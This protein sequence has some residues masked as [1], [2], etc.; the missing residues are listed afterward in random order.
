MDW[1][2][3]TL[4]LAVL[5]ALLGVLLWWRAD[6]RARRSRTGEPPTPSGPPV[7]AEMDPAELAAR[8]TALDRQETAVAETLWAPEMEAQ[9][10]GLLID[11]LWQ[12]LNQT[13]DDISVL[14]TLEFEVIRLPTTG[15]EEAAPLGIRR[16]R[17]GGSQ[18]LEAAGWRRWLEARR[19]EGWRLAAIEFRHIAFDPSTNGLPAR[20]RFLLRLH[21]MR[22]GPPEQRA[23]VTGVMA[24]TW[25][26][27]PEPEAPP[28][29]KRVDLSAIQWALREGRPPFRP[30]LE[31]RLEPPPRSFFTDPLLVR[32]M[33]G[34]GRPKVI[35]ASANTLF[36]LRA[37][38]WVRE[39]WLPDGPG[40]IFTALIE[41]FDADGHLDLLTARFGGLYLFRGKP[42]GGFQ[43]EAEQVWTAEPRLRYA[44]ALT[45][46][47]VDH[48][49]DLD[50]WLGQYKGPYTGGQMPTPW[51]DAN[52][53]HPS[54]LLLNDGHGRFQDAT[55]ERGLAAKRFRR[56]Y[57]ASF[58]DLDLDG[59][60]DLLVVSDFAGVDLYLNDGRGFFRDVTTE[61]IDERHGFGMAHL[62]SD[63][64]RDGLPEVLVTGMHCP[65]AWRLNHL[66][67]TRAPDPDLEM[68]MRRLMTEGCRLYYGTPEGRWRQ[69]P[70]G[71][72]LAL[73][74]WS[75]GCAAPD[76]QNDGFPDV[77]I[78]NGHETRQ[79]ATDYEPYFWLHD[80]HVADSHEDPAKDA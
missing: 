66:G 30:W 72:D 40:L 4:R 61:R 31:A 27:P 44:Q 32:D 56:T 63:F 1:N 68:R 36:R 39:H 42:A 54:W 62:I 74:G 15:N 71:A 73:A 14:G 22:S 24:V 69:L 43:P 77:Y 19:Q 75:W 38:G 80:I 46:G 58:A 49:G 76:V 7:S 57:G 64:N 37:K 53:G 70:T 2:S 12:A 9:R 17:P 78:A 20:S 55:A 28:R 35:M 11:E 67:L 48:D 60:L 79:V 10:H 13:E 47:D 5:L 23:L 6:Q 51:Y 3:R 52:D 8:V 50:V 29:I 34:D 26:V 59:D 65:T 25:A 16:F 41:D 21:A 18:T 33:D 45:C